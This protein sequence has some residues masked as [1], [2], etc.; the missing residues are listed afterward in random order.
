MHS[1]VIRDCNIS[2]FVFR[3]CHS[4]TRSSRV[5]S[6]WPTGDKFEIV[7]KRG[8]V[9]RMLQLL[10]RQGWLAGDP[11]FRSTHVYRFPAVQTPGG[12]REYKREICEAFQRRNRPVRFAVRKAA[13]IRREI[14]QPWSRG[15]GRWEGEEA[16]TSMV[17]QGLPVDRGCGDEDPAPRY[18]AFRH[19]RWVRLFLQIVSVWP[20]RR[21]FHAFTIRNKM[22]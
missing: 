18:R 10:F 7:R 17:S 9:S 1:S 6:S 12:R 13:A 20:F 14:P 15:G 21:H 3:I 5:I 19:A 16:S 2:F 11:R 4:S 8:I 22:P